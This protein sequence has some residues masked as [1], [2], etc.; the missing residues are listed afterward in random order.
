MVDDHVEGEQRAQ[1]RKDAH[2]T[3][4]R[5]F[6]EHTTAGI[7]AGGQVPGKRPKNLDE[8]LKTLSDFLD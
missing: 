4:D 8:A 6:T 2:L 1:A 7:P 3:G 5:P